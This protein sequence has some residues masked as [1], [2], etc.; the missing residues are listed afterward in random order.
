M[1]DIG[2]YVDV[3]ERI[4]QFRSQH[5][6]GSLQPLNPE[7]PF[8]ITMI[9][10]GGKEMIFVV[11][12]AAAYRSPEDTRPGIG[13]AWEKF[14]GDSNF[15]R[16][17]E[18]M[19]AETSAWGRAIVAALAADTQKI[20]T[21]EEIRNRQPD[22]VASTKIEPEKVAQ[23]SFEPTPASKVTTIRSGGISDKQKN[24]LMKLMRERGIS[25]HAGFA[26][27]FFGRDLESLM[28]LA[29]KDASAL[30]KHLLDGGAA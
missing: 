25:D 5:P 29:S 19:N 8:E 27:Q 20:A 11:Y 7:K 6:N 15:T 16:D 21:I 3:A 26:S 10:V 14:P 2:N 18:L 28:D 4:R 17:S 1:F 9:T 24:L 23:S 30:I 22:K 13:I 12:A